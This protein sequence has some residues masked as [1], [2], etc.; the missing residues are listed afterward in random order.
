[1]TLSL[2]FIK[3]F[4]SNITEAFRT[5]EEMFLS[6]AKNF[7][8]KEDCRTKKSTNSELGSRRKSLI[9]LS[10][11]FKCHLLPLSMSRKNLQKAKSY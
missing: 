2:L 7:F 9:P 10:K 11:Q 4:L 3:T 8:D 5:A 6:L 1:M